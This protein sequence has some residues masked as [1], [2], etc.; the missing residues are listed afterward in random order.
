MRLYYNIYITKTIHIYL[1]FINVFSG[2]R[3]LRQ[4]MT[5]KKPHPGKQACGCDVSRLRFASTRY[6]T[7]AKIHSAHC[8]RQCM[9]E[10]EPHPG[11]QACGCG[12]FLSHATHV[13][14]IFWLAVNALHHSHAGVCCGHSRGFFFD[15]CDN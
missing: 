14:Y 4:C 3:C 6:A 15:V 12:F 7:L 8:L 1:D 11:K 2:A 5:E 9:T 13:H 10:K